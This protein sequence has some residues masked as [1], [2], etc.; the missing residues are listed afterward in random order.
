VIVTSR[1]GYWERDI[2]PRLSGS[3]DIRTMPVDEFDDKELA[4]AL[5]P[6]G[7]SPHALPPKVREFVRNPRVCAVAVT[8]LDRLLLQPGELTVDRLLFEYWR[9]RMEERGDLT[10]HT[11]P[12]FE[13]LIRSHARAWLVRPSRSFERDEWD[14]PFPAD[15]E[16][17]VVASE[18][19]IP[20]R[21]S[22]NDKSED[23]ASPDLRSFV[24]DINNPE[25]A[26]RRFSE[27]QGVIN[28]RAAVYIREISSRNM[29]E[30][31]EQ[32]SPWGLKE[33][34]GLDPG[35]IASWLQRI[36]A[37]ED[38]KVLRQ[39]CNLAVSLAKVYSGCDPM[40]SSKV[41]R[42]LV[43]CRPIVNVQVE[44]EEIPLYEHALFSS[45]TSEALESLKIRVFAQALNDSDLQ[46]ATVVA[47]VCGAHE[48]LD[49][50]VQ[51][52]LDSWHPANQ[53]RGLTILG[54]RQPNTASERILSGAA[55][56]GFLGRAKQF[57]FRNYRRAA[58][59]RHWLECLERANDPIDFWRYGTLAETICDSRFLRV[60]PKATASDLLHMFG[61]DLYRRMK[62]KAEERS[63][64][65]RQTL[66]GLKAPEAEIAA[67]I[68]DWKPSGK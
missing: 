47:E 56:P 9:Q 44:P 49:R 18:Q 15:I 64:K 19:A 39:I 33:V 23:S 16:I 12:D 40:L 59:T 27:R 51:G 57:A 5:A 22:V 41:F 6:T 54:F 2:R 45:E 67:A 42:H 1:N 36:L 46:M 30:I 35:R 21:Y 28:E 24:A 17:R 13:K 68:S 50:Y 66:F 55:E 25:M 29:V 62:K 32:P 20:G 43:D 3:L 7:A 14:V 8:L 11:I 26:R 38:P 65:L 37:E 52:L 61:T 34:L 63:K 53:A 60:F 58:W 10:K 48:W 31:G 4:A